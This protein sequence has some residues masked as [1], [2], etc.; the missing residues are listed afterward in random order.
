MSLSPTTC[1]SIGDTLTLNCETSGVNLGI[2]FYQDGTSKGGCVP[3]VP[4][5]CGV[6]LTQSVT[7]TSLV[8]SSFNDTTNSGNWTCEYGATPSP[9]IFIA[10]NPCKYVKRNR[11]LNEHVLTLF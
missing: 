5:T 3:T 9:V 8:I 2:T 6:G 1:F 10:V 11:S 7:T 4:V